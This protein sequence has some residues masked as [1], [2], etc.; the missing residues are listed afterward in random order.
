MCLRYLILMSERIE[1]MFTLTNDGG[2]S[3]R[4]YMVNNSGFR[5]LKLAKNSSLVPGSSHILATLFLVFRHFGCI[6]FIPM[7]SV[8]KARW[9]RRNEK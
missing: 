4:F 3:D 1:F 8:C 6:I 2:V 9:A 5:T 7:F